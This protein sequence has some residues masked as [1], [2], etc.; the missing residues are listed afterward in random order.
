MPTTRAYASDIYASN[1]PNMLGVVLRYFSTESQALPGLRAISPTCTVTRAVFI[2]NTVNTR[3]KLIV[4]T[5]PVLSV[6]TNA[7]FTL[8][9]ITD[10]YPRGGSAARIPVGLVIATANGTV[11]HGA[12]LRL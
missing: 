10:G 5:G 7:Y 4:V 9:G 12:G 1:G 2:T 8:A 11:A 3:N 6:G